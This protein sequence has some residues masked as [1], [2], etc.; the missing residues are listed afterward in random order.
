MEIPRNNPRIVQTSMF[1]VQGWRANVDI[2]YILY[3]DILAK[4]TASDISQ[5]SDY[6]ISYICKGTETSV[7]EKHKLKDLVMNSEECTG[8][9]NNVKR[10]SWKIMNESTKKRII[11]KQESMCH[12]GRLPL[13]LCSENIENVSLSGYRR[14]GTESQAQT[15]F[16]M[17]Y[18]NRRECYNMSLDQYFDYKKNKQSRYSKQNIIPNYVGGN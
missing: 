17:T 18:A 15:T 11:S 6:I 9:V 1:L 8:D 10:L 2:Q 13:F 4:T 14:I 16:I 3:D 5:V 12:V 7:Q